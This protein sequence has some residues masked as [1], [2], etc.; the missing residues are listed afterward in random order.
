MILRSLLI[1][2]TPYSVSREREQDREKEREKRES[3][4]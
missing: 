2:A 4:I 1:E 3:D